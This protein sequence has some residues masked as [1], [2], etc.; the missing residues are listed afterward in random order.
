MSVSSI[1]VRVDNETKSQ[2]ESICTELGLSSSA[3]INTFIRAVVR[4]QGFPF[5]LS[6]MQ[7]PS[8]VERLK[9]ALEKIPTYEIM[10]DKDGN[11]IVD[12]DMPPSVHEW[13][14]NG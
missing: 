8:I 10:F 6:I 3:A 11:V 4:Q 5:P 9:K 7:E 12:D 13:V 2:Y 1:T 14:V